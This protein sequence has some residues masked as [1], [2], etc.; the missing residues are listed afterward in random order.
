MWWLFLVILLSDK[1]VDP[2]CLV[3]IQPKI[4]LF[5]VRFIRSRVTVE[6]WEGWREATLA[7]YNTD[8]EKETESLVWEQ[9][10]QP[11][12]RVKQIEWTNIALLPDTYT[13]V[14]TVTSLY[15]SQGCR[16]IDRMIVRGAEEGSEP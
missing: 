10:E 8:G 1:K 13:V 3:S 15:T 4:A 12:P 6:P 7:L 11:A 9:R 14:L 5:P 16:A 2:P